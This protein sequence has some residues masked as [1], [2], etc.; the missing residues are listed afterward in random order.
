MNLALHK[1]Q[2]L[3]AVVAPRLSR[4]V[5]TSNSMLTQKGYSNPTTP[6]IQHSNTP[7]L[8]HSIPKTIYGFPESA[9]SYL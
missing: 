3:Y 4:K 1:T 9:V 8:Q 7:T 6:Q 5:T 2:L